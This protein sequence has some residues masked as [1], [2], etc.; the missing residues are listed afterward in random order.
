MLLSKFI[1]C[2]SLTV[3]RDLTVKDLILWVRSGH[4]RNDA[5]E[6]DARQRSC[7][8]LYLIVSSSGTF[9]CNEKSGRSSDRRYGETNT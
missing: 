9:G 5:L 2:E 6:G 7:N 8:A 3:R 4:K 1:C